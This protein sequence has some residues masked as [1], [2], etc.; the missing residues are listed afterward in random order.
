MPWAMWRRWL[1][2]KW[3]PVPSCS[4]PW[5]TFRPD[6]ARYCM[7]T[8]RPPI[9]PRNAPWKPIMKYACCPSSP[10]Y[11]LFRQ[12]TPPCE[13]D[14]AT[15]A[16]SAAFWE[17][18]GRGWLGLT[19]GHGSACNWTVDQDILTRPVDLLMQHWPVVKPGRFLL[20][21]KRRRRSSPARSLRWS[22]QQRITCRTGRR[23]QMKECQHTASNVHKV[24]L[25]LGIDS[26]RIFFGRLSVIVGGANGRPSSRRYSYVGYLTLSRITGTRNE[27]NSGFFG[28]G[29]AQSKQF[30]NNQQNGSAKFIAD[31]IKRFL[32][33]TKQKKNAMPRQCEWF[34]SFKSLAPT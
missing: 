5:T 12:S 33:P 8:A 22:N 28:S 3:V 23:R 16:T 26:C 24:P 34:K 27:P 17:L 31:A 20:G 15:W 30:W 10:L 7:T 29:L 32:P 18:R 21:Q 25:W 13:E 6:W 19:Q 4:N 14:V 2:R 11:S 9:H 1:T